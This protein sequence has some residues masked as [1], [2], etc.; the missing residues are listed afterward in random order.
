MGKEITTEEQANELV[1]D[2]LRYR[3]DNAELCEKWGITA[4]DIRKIRRPSS[5]RFLVGSGKKEILSIFNLWTGKLR[6]RR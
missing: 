4:R 1:D 2:V 5:I 3:L 6:H